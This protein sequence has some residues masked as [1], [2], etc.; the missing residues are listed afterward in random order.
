[1]YTPVNPTFNVL[2][3]GSCMSEYVGVLTWL[4]NIL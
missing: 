3:W 4:I 1:M 2:E